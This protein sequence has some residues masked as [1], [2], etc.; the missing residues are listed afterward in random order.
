MVCAVRKGSSLRK[1]A[2]RFGVSLATVELWV[3][4][5]AATRLDRVDFTNRPCGSRQAVNRTP[6]RIERLILKVRRELK[7]KSPL[8]QH[9]ARAIRQALLWQGT[10]ACPCIRTIGR[11]LERHGLLDVRQRVRRPPPPKGWYLPDVAAGRAEIDSFDMV[12]DLV[13]KGGHDVTVFNA[14]SLHGGL[15]GSFP[16][17]RITAKIAAMLMLEHWR[18]VGLPTY[19]KFD[20]D[21]VFQGPRQWPD[22][23]G[24]VIRLCLQLGVTPVFAPPCEPGFQAEIEA[25]NGRWQRMVWRR[26][27]HRNREELKKRSH[28]FVAALREST[29]A[30]I[31]S[32]PERKAVP[33]DFKQ[34]Y[35]HRLAGRVIYLRRTDQ[36]GQVSCLGHR[37]RVDK[38]WLHRLVRIEVDLSAKEVRIYR[39]R[40]RDPD[41]QPLLKRYGYQMPKQRLRG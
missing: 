7:D 6:R 4:R 18:S 16:E 28:R 29:A 10:H 35:A 8:G 23:L 2:R 17:Q 25:Y 36:S 15:A 3:A 5:A 9:G 21:L 40:R 38:N 13:L 12:T 31:A 22:R 1:V 14:M 39:L 37:W 19:A 27:R 32:A 34:L 24:R 20:N 26:F 11:I 41:D 30:R 33:E